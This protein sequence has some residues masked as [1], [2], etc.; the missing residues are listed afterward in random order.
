MLPAY[1][2]QRRRHARISLDSSGEY[3]GLPEK[4]RAP[5]LFK[6][7]GSKFFGSKTILREGCLMKL[8]LWHPH[9]AL[10]DS[11]SLS[12]VFAKHQFHQPNRSSRPKLAI[13]YPKHTYWCTRVHMAQERRQSVSKHHAKI[14]SDLSVHTTA[15]GFRK[16]VG[17]AKTQISVRFRRKVTLLVNT[18][19][20]QVQL[21]TI[22]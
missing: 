12:P 5:G 3:W 6:L 17:C 10:K 19:F 9:I 7:V 8:C 22:R 1:S 2:N 13:L 4:K 11:R 18:L 15:N 16:G 20:L 21:L 14:R